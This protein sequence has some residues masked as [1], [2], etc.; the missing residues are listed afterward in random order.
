MESFVKFL[1]YY[2]TVLAIVRLL[3]SAFRK[4]PHSQIHTASLDSA[5]AVEYTILAVIAWTLLR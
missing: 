3:T 4:Y 5:V 2:F 1:A